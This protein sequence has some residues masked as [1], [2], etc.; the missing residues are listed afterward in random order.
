MPLKSALLLVTALVAS[1]AQ[2]AWAAQ[3]IRSVEQRGK[4]LLTD[5]CA[6]CH[7]IDRT[8]A[9]THREAPPF[10]TL[11]PRYPIDALAEALGDGLATGHPDM[12]E[13]VLEITDGKANLADLRAIQE[14][15]IH[16]P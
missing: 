6:R 5:N 12:P 9:S 1:S 10:H 8:G 2:T 11:G 13:S 16:K 4:V 15:T 3:N 7:A 14:P